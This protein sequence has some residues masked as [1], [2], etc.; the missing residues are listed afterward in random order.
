MALN[1][2]SNPVQGRRVDSVMRLRAVRDRIYQSGEVAT[3]SGKPL[4]V[5]PIGLTQDRGE[6]LR[7]LV[8]REQAVTA[9]ETGFAFGLSASWLLEGL[10][11]EA[12]ARGMEPR[13]TSV[14]P[15]AT[16]A[17]R[18][19]GVRHLREAGADGWHELHRFGSEL[20]LPR[21]VAEGRR[22]DLVF[23]DGDHR[24]E[25]VFSDV[26]H[27]RRLVR[28]G[29][30]IVIDDAWMPSVRKCAAF[31]QSASLIDIEPSEADTALAK[32]IVARVDPRGDD[33]AWDHFAEF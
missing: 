24:F 27:A 2:E 32:Y 11:A 28:A 22:Y 10:W 26:L 23:I 21:L 14:D 6:A 20:V 29:G 33:R 19:A 30:L 8:I 16:K 9:L 12:E 15:F 31:F 18:D 7:D 17:W 5:W 13:L 4:P 3:E 1:L 25:Y